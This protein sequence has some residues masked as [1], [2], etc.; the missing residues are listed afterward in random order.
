MR[1]T[2]GNANDRLFMQEFLKEEEKGMGDT[3]HSQEK[4]RYLQRSG[5]K[6]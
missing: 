1:R 6:I 5:Y 2:I 4:K 3:K